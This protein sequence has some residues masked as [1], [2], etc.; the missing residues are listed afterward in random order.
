[1]ANRKYIDYKPTVYINDERLKLRFV[2]GNYGKNTLVCVGIN[3][4]T[5]N[6]ESSDNTMNDLIKFSKNNGY[7]G[8]IMIN[9]YPLIC[10]KPDDLPKHLDNKICETNMSYIKSVFDNDSCNVLLLSWGDYITRNSDFKEK[11]SNIINMAK[12][13]NMKLI[14]INSLTKLGNPRHFRNLF[15]DKNYNNGVYTVNE[16]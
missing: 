16:F 15:R 1:M 11:A 3:P 8:C 5:A 12:E 2:I 6:A 9:P 14:H 4:N 7:D 10:S 13:H